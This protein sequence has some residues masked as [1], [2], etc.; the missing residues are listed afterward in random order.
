MY[1]QLSPPSGRIAE[2][3]EKTR[4]EFEQAELPLPMSPDR[5]GP[6]KLVS[7]SASESM[8]REMGRGSAVTVDPLPTSEASPNVIN[9]GLKS[10][11]LPL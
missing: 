7:R 9:V 3:V 2:A 8:S 11:R 5:A 4:H 1:I 10:D 6:T